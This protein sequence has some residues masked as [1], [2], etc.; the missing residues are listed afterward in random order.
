MHLENNN[1]IKQILENFLEDP[2][3]SLAE[4]ARGKKKTVLCLSFLPKFLENEPI[5]DN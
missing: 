2:F 5:N 3:P 4:L 1:E